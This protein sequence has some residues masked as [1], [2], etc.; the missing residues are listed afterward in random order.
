MNCYLCGKEEAENTPL[1]SYCKDQGEFHK[2][3][4][5][6][7]LERRCIQF[8]Q[9]IENL[10]GENMVLKEKNKKLLKKTYR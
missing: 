9:A 4:K 5:V 3:H 2:V 7:L 6:C 8:Q 1:D 10:R